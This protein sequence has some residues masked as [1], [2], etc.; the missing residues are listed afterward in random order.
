MV[1]LEGFTPDLVRVEF[2][3]NKITS[4]RKFQEKT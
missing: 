4:G 1:R 2:V 3:N